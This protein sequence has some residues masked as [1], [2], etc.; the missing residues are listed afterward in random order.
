MIIRGNLLDCY[1]S[2]TR[3]SRLLSCSNLLLFMDHDDTLY[4]EP[5][6]FT[7]SAVTDLFF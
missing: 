1:L 6:V 3:H 5:I 2:I 7:D 4:H